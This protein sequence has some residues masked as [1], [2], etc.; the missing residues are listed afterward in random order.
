MPVSGQHSDSER[1]S[2][3]RVAHRPSTGSREHH[4]TMHFD[5]DTRSAPADTRGIGRFGGRAL[6]GWTAVAVGIV[7]FLL[8]WLLVQRSWPPLAALDA[9]GPISP[10]RDPS[11]STTGGCRAR[12]GGRSR[13]R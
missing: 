11:R 2:P 6:L 12:P 13:W 5:L 10:V 4:P 8:L 1:Q 3:H 7:P 9:R